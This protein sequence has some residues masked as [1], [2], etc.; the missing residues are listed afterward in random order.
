MSRDDIYN[1]LCSVFFQEEIRLLNEVSQIE[2]MI[3]Y[4]GADDGSMLKL[5]QARAKL[6]YFR[7]YIREILDFLKYFDG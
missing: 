7:T 6:N 4:R 5:I 2:Y 1:A 3:R